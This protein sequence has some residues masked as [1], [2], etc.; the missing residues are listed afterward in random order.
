MC[1]SDLALSHSKKTAAG[2]AERREML[3]K[4]GLPEVAQEAF[5]YPR[6]HVARDDVLD[7]CAAAWSARRILRGTALHF[8]ATDDRDSRGLLMR[9]H[10]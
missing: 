4:H 3:R 10:A 9:I 1:S 8:P 7:A 2:E 5:S 6:Q